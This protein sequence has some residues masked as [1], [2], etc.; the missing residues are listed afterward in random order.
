MS[1][2]C[3]GMTLTRMNLQRLF[4]FYCVKE[5][6]DRNY[7]NVL[8]GVAGCGKALYKSSSKLFFQLVL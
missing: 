4:E 1:K 7:N 2:F 5:N 3:L 6:I 8:T